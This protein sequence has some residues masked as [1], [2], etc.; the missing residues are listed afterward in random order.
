MH[1][2]VCFEALSIF[3]Y[4]LDVLDGGHR[5]IDVLTDMLN[6]YKLAD[7]NYNKVII[8]DMELDRVFFASKEIIRNESYHFKLDFR[9]TSKYAT[10]MRVELSENGD[11]YNFITTEHDG[12]ISTIFIGK[13]V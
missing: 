5:D 3:F 4:C 8:D 11:R 12:L 6:M 9:T 2:Q 10:D 7:L 1:I 13:F